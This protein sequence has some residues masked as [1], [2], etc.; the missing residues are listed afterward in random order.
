[1]PALPSVGVE[2]LDAQDLLDELC[3]EQLAYSMNLACLEQAIEQAPREAATRAAIA[4]LEARYRDLVTVRDALARIHHASIE[5]RV[6]RI[7]V[8]DSA[9]TDY[10]RGLYAWVHAIVRALEHLAGTLR[11]RQ[12]PVDWA[13]LRW[14]I[15]EAKNFHFDEL[16]PQ[17][18]ADVATLAAVPG[19]EFIDD[20][21]ER[22]FAAAALLET[23]LDQRFA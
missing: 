18:R 1:M 9:L 8:T 5:R 10:L 15:E 7:F 11:T 4:T 22:T 20:A 19:A 3:E 13:L 14:R 6:Q 12:P 17:I 23:R 21:V 2:H 16:I